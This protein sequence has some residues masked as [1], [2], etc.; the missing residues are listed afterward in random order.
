MPTFAAESTIAPLYGAFLLP[1][2]SVDWFAQ[3]ILGA[4]N[5]MTNRANWV[6]ETEEEIDYAVRESINMVS[7]Y[8]F[9]NFNPFP[10]GLILPFGGTVAPAG[11][12]ACD[13]ASYAADDYPELYAAIGYYFGG[14]GANFNVP[15]LVNRVPVGSGGD[16]SHASTGG[17]SEHTLSVS[18][19]PSHSHSIGRTITTPVLEPGEVPALTPVPIIPDYTGNEGGDLPHN[20]MQPYQ[21]VTYII[22]AGRD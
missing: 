9:L 12:L 4:I 8:Q 19:L 15:N 16:Y 1:F 14:S 18:E 7:Q 3:N 22:Y 2:P 10:P 11:Y 5:E 13:G 17:E 6:G 20:N 21:A